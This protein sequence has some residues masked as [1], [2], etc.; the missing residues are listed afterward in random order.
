VIDLPNSPRLS[1]VGVEKVPVGYL[2]LFGAGIDR[3]VA[4][5]KDGHATST[6]YGGG[7]EGF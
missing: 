2:I 3:F 4:V 5:A 7:I 1:L 6:F